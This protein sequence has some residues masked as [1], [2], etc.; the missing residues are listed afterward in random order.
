MS[1]IEESH[2][3]SQEPET[4]DEVIRVLIREMELFENMLKKIESI[5]V[6]QG[7]SM[8]S[9]MEFEHLKKSHKKLSTIVEGLQESIDEEPEKKLS[10]LT[11]A[12]GVILAAIAAATAVAELLEKK[13]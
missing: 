3:F 8:V 4:R 2:K 9:E 7:E 6:R 10:I 11:K 5:V 12:L 13:P 1:S